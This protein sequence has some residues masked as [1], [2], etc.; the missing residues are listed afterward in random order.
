M[1]LCPDCYGHKGHMVLVM[2]AATHACT[3]QY[4]PCRTC[5]DTG[6]VAEAV[7]L[8]LANYKAQGDWMR[9]ERVHVGQYESL[10]DVARRWGVSPAV[11]SG[12]EH[13]KLDVWRMWLE[14]QE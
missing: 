3:E 13:G 7:A 11:V 12:L 1:T 2:H 10:M 5:G 6:E 14:A 4:Q 8:E 9:N